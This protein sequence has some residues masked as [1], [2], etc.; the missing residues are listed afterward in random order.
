M[1]IKG[2]KD[3]NYLITRSTKGHIIRLYQV[4][5]EDNGYLENENPFTLPILVDYKGMGESL[6]D[7]LEE[8]D[9]LRERVR[10]YEI[11]E[12]NAL[13]KRITVIENKLNAKRK[14]YQFWRR[15]GDK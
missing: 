5:G 3:I 7:I 4:D 12:G 15:G 1:T 6:V 8:R 9:N 10:S 14:W 11:N 2:K 13:A